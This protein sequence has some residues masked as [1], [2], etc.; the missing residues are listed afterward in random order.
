VVVPP[1]AQDLFC[2]ITSAGQNVIP[3]ASDTFLGLITGLLRFLT[4]SAAV[5]TDGGPGR[6]GFSALGMILFLSLSACGGDSGTP[7]PVLNIGISPASVP[8]GQTAI[9]T[10]YSNNASMCQASGAWMGSRS[11]SGSLGVWQAAPG[12]YTYMLACSSTPSG[13]ASG[14]ATLT[15]T[16]GAAPLS[17]LPAALSNGV[18]GT[19]YN[20]SLQATGGV[21]PFAWMVSSGALPRGLSLSNSTTNTVTVSGTPDASTQGA[22]FTIQVADSVH[23]TATQPFTVSIAGSLNCGSGS[24]NAGGSP[25]IW[26]WPRYGSQDFMKFFEPNAAW[27]QV[28]PHVRVVGLSIEALTQTSQSDLTTI[29]TDLRQRNMP[30][31]L[32]ML[33][34]PGGGPTGCGYQVEGYSAP[35]QT[36]QIANNV[37]ALGS[38]P[39]AYSMDEP[40]YYGHFYTGTNACQTDLPTLIQQVAQSVR[41]ARSVFPGVEIGETEPIMAVTQGGLTDLSNW[42][43]FYQQTIGE[44]LGFMTFDMDWSSQWSSRIPAVITLLRSKGVAVQVIYNGSGSA[45]SDGNWTGEA[46]TH[47]Q[48]FEAIAKPDGA[49][50]TSWNPHP[51]HMLPDSDPTTLTGLVNSY[52]HYETCP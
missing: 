32:A 27:S 42:L 8:A 49:R 34:L 35:G 52:I 11:T 45:T 20:Q 7:A 24:T 10:W 16:P 22:A 29:L 30:I 36:R 26:L 31:S 48:A 13:V 51:S 4:T 25:E 21:A 38:V 17:I 41:D 33:P 44:P 37:K 12:T 1:E 40:L 3:Q 5:S 43:D 46:V 6:V 15:V 2:P 23:Q 9:L 18:V 47:F 50:F 39:K 19:P 14:S 28:A